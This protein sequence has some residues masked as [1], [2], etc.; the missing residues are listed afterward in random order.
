MDLLLNMFFIIKIESD[1]GNFMNDYW[2]FL[3]PAVFLIIYSDKIDEAAKADEKL[4]KV[5]LVICAGVVLIKLIRIVADLFI[6]T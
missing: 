1:K 3:I 2:W 6:P 5:I 4:K